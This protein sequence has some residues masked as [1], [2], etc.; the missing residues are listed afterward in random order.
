ME[1]LAIGTIEHGRQSF[2]LH[3]LF[4][5]RVRRMRSSVASPL[6]SFSRPSIAFPA[7]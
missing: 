4:P 2:H 7:S 3:L 1:M 5:L 6:C